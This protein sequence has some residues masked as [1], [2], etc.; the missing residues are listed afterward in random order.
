MVDEDQA[1]AA[2]VR[3]K[4][5]GRGKS[6]VPNDSLAVNGQGGCKALHAGV[7]PVLALHAAPSKAGLALPAPLC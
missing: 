3:A 6:S 4:P 2:L 7:V 1:A 5:H